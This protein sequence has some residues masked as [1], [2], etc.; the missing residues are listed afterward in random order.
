M[1]TL[2][3]ATSAPMVTRERS[4]TLRIEGRGSRIGNLG[5]RIADLREQQVGFVHQAEAAQGF[6]KVYRF[7]QVR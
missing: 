6:V 3:T 1:I 7:R 4:R 2:V 5:L